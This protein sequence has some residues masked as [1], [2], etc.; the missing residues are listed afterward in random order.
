MNRTV[1][2]GAAYAVDGKWDARPAFEWGESIERSLDGFDILG[3]VATARRRRVADR[4]LN[5]D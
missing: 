4:R 3:I 2:L 1:S 5:H